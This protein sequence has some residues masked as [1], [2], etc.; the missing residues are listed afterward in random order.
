MFKTIKARYDKGYVTDEQ[1]GRYVAQGVIT[2]DQATEIQG[3][4]APV[5]DGTIETAVLDA[6]Y[7]EGVNSYE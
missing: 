1:L 3:G 6:A 4:S 7:R 5:P 2:E